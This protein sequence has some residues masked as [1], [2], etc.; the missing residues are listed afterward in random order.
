MI[1]PTGLAAELALLTQ[2]LD[3][4]GTDI[5]QTVTRLTTATRTAVGSYL[6]LSITI[7]AE[8]AP[9]QLTVLEEGV[10]ATDIGTSLLIPL[11]TSET[12]M[13]PASAELTLYAA[14]PGAFIDLAADLSFITG[15][16]STEFAIDEYRNTVTST[17]PTGFPIDQHG[18]TS[19][20]TTPTGLASASIIN[21]ALGV[22][23]GRGATPEQADHDL[24]Q[25]A[26]TAGI[27]LLT[28][29]TLILAAPSPPIPDRP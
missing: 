6:G 4:P 19:A 21:Q 15:R 10:V 22:L 1:L 7:T 12:T 29:A 28:A 20:S 3:L 13:T 11:S 25:H 5:A 14:T 26:A 18:N 9:F 2:A 24:H 27:A 23:M 8:P 17:I 16:T